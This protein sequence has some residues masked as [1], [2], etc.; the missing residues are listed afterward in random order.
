MGFWTPNCESK[1][2]SAADSVVF[3]GFLCCCL[4]ERSKVFWSVCKVVR[5]PLAHALDEECVSK[6]ILLIIV[7]GGALKRTA[8]GR[9][10]PQGKKL[11]D[12][13]MGYP[14]EDVV[15]QQQQPQL[16]DPPIC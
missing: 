5:G 3:L 2:M 16:R 8:G 15:L 7:G 11:F 9:A 4:V 6:V 1:Q 14:G 13:T 12:C 10:T